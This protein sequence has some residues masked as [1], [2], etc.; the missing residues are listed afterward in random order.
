MRRVLIVGP[1]ETDFMDSTVCKPRFEVEV[2]SRRYEGL[3]VRTTIDTH[4]E[5]SHNLCQHLRRLD[6]M[7]QIAIGIQLYVSGTIVRIYRNDRPVRW[8]LNIQHA[9]FAPRRR[10]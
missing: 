5:A 2:L 9:A 6:R 4:C 10:H 1:I 7:P 3:Q 8:E